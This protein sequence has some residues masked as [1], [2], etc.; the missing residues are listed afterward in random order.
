[1]VAQHEGRWIKKELEGAAAIG[2]LHGA[3]T[4][5]LGA[6]AIARNIAALLK[7]FGGETR[8]FARSSPT[9]VIRSREQLDAALPD[10]DVV[11]NTLPHTT[12]TIGLID[13]ARLARFRSTALFVN[14]GRGSVLNE[15]ALLETLNAGRLG[16]AVLDVTSIEPLPPGHPFWTHPRIILTQHTGGRF[17]GETAAKVTRF[18][19]NFARFSR[20]ESLVGTLDATR[21]Y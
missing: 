11:I 14:M 7:P 5:I 17:P 19:E 10:V 9:A 16:G 20:G 3:Q 4:I 1:M 12:E 21:G 15:D 13:R 18:L 8:F 2:Q 6:G